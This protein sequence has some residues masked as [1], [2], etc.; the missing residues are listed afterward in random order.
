VSCS[1]D[2]A[3]IGS[4]TI[5]LLQSSSSNIPSHSWPNQSS[6]MGKWS[7][8]GLHKVLLALWWYS[9]KWPLINCSVIRST[10]VCVCLAVFGWQPSRRHADG[11]QEDVHLPA[12]EWAQGVQSTQLLQSVHDGPPATQH[13]RTEGHDRILHRSHHQAGGDEPRAGLLLFLILV[14]LH[15]VVLLSKANF[16][17]LAPVWVRGCRIG[18]LRL[19]WGKLEK[20]REFEWSGKVR[21]RSGDT[22]FL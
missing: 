13:R 10:C 3:T 15:P 11:T 8:R 17:Y 19:R 22:I 6:D 14:F 1:N 5:L 7:S 9:M 4:Y 21:E 12:G 18:P 16:C 2:R 20:V